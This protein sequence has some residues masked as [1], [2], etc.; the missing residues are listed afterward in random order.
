M[1]RKRT[2]C[3]S[4]IAGRKGVN[5]VRAY[6][7]GKGGALYL[8]WT[9]S[10]VD[11]DTGAPQREKQ[12]LSL[13]AAGIT[14]YTAAIAKAEETAEKFGQ[15]DAAP[16]AGPLTLDRL[17][18]LDLAEV[19]PTKKPNTQL[20]DR[21]AARMFLAFFGGGAVV[22]VTGPDG[23]LKSEVGRLRNDAFINARREGKVEGFPR[24]VRHRI[25]QYDV[26]FLRAVFNWAMVERVDGTVLLS[27]NP[28][29]GFPIPMES[30]P[31]G[32]R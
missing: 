16:T 22:E 29:N 18:T 12:R 6:E 20:H 3:W 31:A 19:T 21:Q 2:E 32:R 30:N 1:A 26:K 24:R 23:R 14:S 8:E 17:L 15:L 7:D 9:E 10:A 5:R 4:Y 11:P 27:R 13:T 28:W 25:I